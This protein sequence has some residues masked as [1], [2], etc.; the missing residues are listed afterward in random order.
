[1][2][3]ARGDD[4]THRMEALGLAV[5]RQRG[6]HGPMAVPHRHGDLELNLPLAGRFRYVIGGRVVAVPEGRLAALWGAAAHQTLEVPADAYWATVGLETALGWGLPDRLQKRL[7]AVGVVVDGAARERDA[8]RFAEWASDLRAGGESRSAVL[9]EMEARLRRLARDGAGAPDAPEEPL[10][11]PAE[12]VR[13]M[14][15]FI[16]EH[17]RE[18]IDVASVAR[19]GALHPNHAMT[20]FRR[21]TGMTIVGCIARQRVAH[22]QRRLATSADPAG[23][24]ALESGFGS[25]SRFHEAFRRETGTTPTRFRRWVAGARETGA[26]E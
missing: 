7:L 2:T 22:A 15:A 1:M 8:A 26:I 21:H 24:I 25:L 12:A 16:A 9:L 4:P 19:A 11:G 17:Y 23:R 6:V 10:A 18:P 14:A 3:R 20:C 13:R 5:W